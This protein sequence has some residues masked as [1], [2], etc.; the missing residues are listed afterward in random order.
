MDGVVFPVT[1]WVGLCF[2][3]DFSSLPPP[4]SLLR[5][6]VGVALFLSGLLDNVRAEVVLLCLTSK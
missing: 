2:D 1:P 6:T 3:A 5:D 4:F